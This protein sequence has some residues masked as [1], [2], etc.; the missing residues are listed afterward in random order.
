MAA[1]ASIVA[2]T[3]KS[4]G[5]SGTCGCTAA[6]IADSASR[7]AAAT[8]SANP[9]VAIARTASAAVSCAATVGAGA[10]G[11]GAHGARRRASRT[12]AVD[13]RRGYRRGSRRGERGRERVVGHHPGQPAIE[14]RRVPAVERHAVTGHH[15]LGRSHQRLVGHHLDRGLHRRSVDRRVALEQ[16]AEMLHSAHQHHTA[17]ELRAG[18]HSGHQ[19][20]HAERPVGGP[21]GEVHL[22]VAQVHRRGRGG[23]Q[24]QFAGEPLAPGGLDHV[25]RGPRLEAAFVG[26]QFRRCTKGMSALAAVLLR[27]TR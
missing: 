22:P 24:R 9:P 1:A 18:D 2:G 17:V 8:S 25:P 11:A 3:P 16:P 5:H 12:G 26:E 14:P 19:Q 7:T 13:D 27:A 15:L 6:S 21:L 4:C 20:S 10:G 23:G